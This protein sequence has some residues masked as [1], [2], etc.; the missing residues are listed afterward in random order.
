MRGQ[1]LVEVALCLPVVIVLALGSVAMVRIED[2]QSGLDAATLAA[3]ATAARAPDQA[4]ALNAAH[5][6]FATVLTA[7]PVRSATLTMSMPAFARGNVVTF[8]AGCYVDVG[9][10][11]LPG[12]PRSFLLRSTVT[13]PLQLWRSHS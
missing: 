13:E 6:R 3:S 5:A 10:A 9:W 4:T 7:Y 1:S 2:A 12:L 8:S 11:A